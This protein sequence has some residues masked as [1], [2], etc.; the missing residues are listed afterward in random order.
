MNVIVTG[1]SSGIGYETVKAL[2]KTG[3]NNIIA[4]ARRK[5]LLN[6]LVKEC[7]AFQSSKVY[8]LPFDLNSD[9]YSEITSL[10]KEKFHSIDI[11]LNNAGILK[12]KPFQELTKSD[13]ENLFNTNFY[14][15]VKLIQTCLPMF[16]SPSHIVNISSMGGFQGSVKFPGLSVYSATKSAVCSLTEAIAEEFKPLN[17]HVNCLAIGAVQTEMLKKAFPDYKAVVTAAEISSFISDFCMNGHKYFNGKIL[18]VSLS[19]P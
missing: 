19:T 17:I 12:S 9:D 5:D 14:N 2:A 16:N 15:T 18:P 10:I 3:E 8:S 11:L 1:A 4:I 13:C 7:T 6:K